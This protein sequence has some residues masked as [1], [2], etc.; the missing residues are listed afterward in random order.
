MNTITVTLAP[1]STKELHQ[2]GWGSPRPPLKDVIAAPHQAGGSMT[3]PASHQDSKD[4]RHTEY[5]L[6]QLSSTAHKAHNLAL[7]LKLELF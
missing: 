1:G 7:T 5:K 6:E 2:E 4:G 3:L